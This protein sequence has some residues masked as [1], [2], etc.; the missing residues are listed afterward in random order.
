[1]CK[2]VPIEIKK[3]KAFH[4]INKTVVVS[5]IIYHPQINLWAAKALLFR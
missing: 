1:M 5:I 3:I 2:T 4:G